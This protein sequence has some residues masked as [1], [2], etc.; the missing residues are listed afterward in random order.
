MKRIYKIGMITLLLGSLVVAAGA[1]DMAPVIEQTEITMKNIEKTQRVIEKTVFDFIYKSNNSK[2]GFTYELY[3]SETYHFTFIGDETRAYSGALK[4]FRSVNGQW[5]L[6]KQYTATGASFN[7][8]FNPSQG[9]LYNLEYSCTLRKEDERA[10]IG[11]IID[12][13]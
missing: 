11:L 10:G 5:Q 9:G 4:I 6:D 8:T 1:Q 7:V 13:E 3:G 12:R 2:Y